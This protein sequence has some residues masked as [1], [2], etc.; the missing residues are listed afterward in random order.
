M[1]ILS[2]TDYSTEK[3][4]QDLRLDI[5]TIKFHITNLHTKLGVKNRAG[6]MLHWW[7]TI[8]TE[9]ILR[10]LVPQTQVKD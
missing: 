2:T 8:N 3:I 1:K 5:K 9:A 6:V 10:Q 4:A 7:K